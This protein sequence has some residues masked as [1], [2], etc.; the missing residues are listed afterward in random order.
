M[1]DHIFF[2]NALVPLLAGVIRSWPRTSRLSAGVW[3]P[4][5]S[6]LHGHRSDSAPRFVWGRQGRC[7]CLKS[8]RLAKSLGRHGWGAVSSS[9]TA[10]VLLLSIVITAGAA[11]ARPCAAR[12]L[13]SATPATHNPE[14]LASAYF[15]P[16]PRV[17]GHCLMWRVS[18]SA[19]SWAPAHVPGPSNQIHPVRR[20]RNVCADRSLA[21]HPGQLGSPGRPRRSAGWPASPL[22]MRHSAATDRHP[23]RAPPLAD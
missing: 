8:A 7:H 1:I 17:V 6:A 10:A 2:P 5:A 16:A 13:L 20:L 22:G 9:L 23:S 18:V 14:K 15:S 3:C 4:V 19:Q 11:D 12:H 21:G